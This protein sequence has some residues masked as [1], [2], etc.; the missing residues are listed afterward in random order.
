MSQ[1]RKLTC[2]NVLTKVQSRKVQ[3][4]V[5]AAWPLLRLFQVFNANALSLYEAEQIGPFLLLDAAKE[6]FLRRSM[7]PLALRSL[8]AIDRRS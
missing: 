8:T 2:V 3:R 1:S 6:K 5:V 4:R 7:Q